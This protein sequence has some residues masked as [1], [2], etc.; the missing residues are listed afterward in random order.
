MLASSCSKEDKLS[1]RDAERKT[2]FHAVIEP[3]TKV[4]SDEKLKVRWNEGDKI[5]IF[6]KRTLNDQY[7]FLGEDGDTG[8]DFELIPYSGFSTGNDIDYIVAV[9]PYA[10]GSGNKINNAGNKVTASVAASQNFKEGSVGVGANLMVAMIDPANGDDQFLSFK[11]VCGFIRLR[12]YGDNASVSSV[13]LTGN[14]EEKIAG[15][16]AIVPS[17]DKD[18]TITMDATATTTVN[19]VCETAVTLGTSATDYTEFVVAIP[20]VTFT[21]GFTIVVTNPDGKTFT[22]STTKSLTVSRN[23]MESMGAIKVSFAD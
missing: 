21:G 19:L 22:K 8:G 7:A 20:P 11:N 6:N 1:S 16:A 3:G 5:T 23:K 15:K 18:P 2:V 14:N 4:Y 12:L 10:K 13:S 17:V 9:Y